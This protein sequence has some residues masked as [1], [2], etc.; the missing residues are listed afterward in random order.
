MSDDDG[1]FRDIVKTGS[2]SGAGLPVRKAWA[3]IV[4]DYRRTEEKA[5][6][7]AAYEEMAAASII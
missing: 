1:L 2:L 3:K 4:E 6:K 5:G 7:R